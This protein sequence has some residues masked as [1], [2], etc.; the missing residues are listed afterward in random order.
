MRAGLPGKGR[1]WTGRDSWGQGLPGIWGRT[2][3][4]MDTAR[5]QEILSWK[6]NVAWFDWNRVRDGIRPG[7]KCWSSL[8]AA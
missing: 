8:N 1:V 2:S 4:G 6:S 5:R 3:K 7:P